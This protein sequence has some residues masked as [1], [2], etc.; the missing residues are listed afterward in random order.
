MQAAGAARLPLEVFDGVGDIYF[1]AVDA[2]FRQDLVEQASSRTDKRPALPVL[3]IAG[4]LAHENDVRAVGGPSPKT[5]CVAR[6]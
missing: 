2:D 6:R 5:V 3:L 4:L 1:I